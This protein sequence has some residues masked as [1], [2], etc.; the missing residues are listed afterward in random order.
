[1]RR[2]AVEFNNIA[3]LVRFEV[4]F[5]ANGRTINAQELEKILLE[6][7]PQ[8]VKTC[9]F[10]RSWEKA[11]IQDCYELAENQQRIREV[12]EERKLV[13]FCANGSILP[14]KSGVSSQPLKGAIEFQSPES[15]EISI[16]LPFGNSI[17]G[18]G[19]PEA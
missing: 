10:Y 18:M 1:M 11:K 19:I 2:T 7:L 9:L 3:L 5:P 17:R 14:R 4:G 12:L 15:M 16:D 6:F 8:I 13:A